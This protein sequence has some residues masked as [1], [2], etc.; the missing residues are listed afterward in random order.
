MTN[1]RYR[2]LVIA[3]VALATVW[4][5]AWAGYRIAG[6]QRM[7]AEKFTAF[8]GGLDLNKLEAEKRARALR[9]LADRLNRLPAEERRKVRMGR[10]RSDRLFDQMTEEEKGNFIDATMPTGFK[11]MLS[12]FEQLPEDKRKLA[13][14]RA[15]KQLRSAHEGDMAGPD[16]GGRPPEVSPE[17]QKKIVSTGLKT[18]YLNSSAQTKAEVAPLL[19]E[20]QRAM[21]GGRLFHP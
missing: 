12:S 1:P 15:V 2:P 11:Q 4:L 3:G 20:I 14:N 5:I 10:G 18:F 17:L 19:E 9:E 21:E 6:S 13:I 7:T 8:A 16:G